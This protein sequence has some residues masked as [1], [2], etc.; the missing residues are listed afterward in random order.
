M[1]VKAQNSRNE[2]R[3]EARCA[4]ARVLHSHRSYEAARLD[5]RAAHNWPE[6][7]F[8]VKQI[9]SQTW[10]IPKGEVEPK[11][12]YKLRWKGWAASHDAWQHNAPS[13]MTRAWFQG[14]QCETLEHHRETLKARKGG[15]D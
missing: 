12:F 14:N 11:P 10:A 1:L 9:L 4:K 5:A 8:E 6:Q 15:L 3:T 2:L 7:Q 13:E